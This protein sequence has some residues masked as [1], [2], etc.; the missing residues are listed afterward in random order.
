MDHCTTDAVAFH[1]VRP[2]ARA[3]WGRGEGKAARGAT[4]QAASDRAHFYTWAAK[5]GTLFMNTKYEP[6]K[7]YDV[8]GKWPEDLWW[9]HKLDHRTYAQYS[10]KCRKGHDAR[11]RD[12]NAVLRD[13]AEARVEEE[14]EKR[15]GQLLT[16][17]HPFR[18]LRAVLE[19]E[20]QYLTVRPRYKILIL[21]AD[22]RAG[23]TCFAEALFERPFVVT[24]EGSTFLDLKGFD[25]ATHDGLVLDNVNSFRQ[26]L[27]WRAVLQARNAKTKGGQSA[28][29]MYSR[30]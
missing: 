1:G 25:R 12:L 2:N 24:V 18:K 26:L 3:T 29:Q 9:Q 16:L 30:P 23:K 7:D 8:R 19:W 15:K 21:H 10:L 22:S 14:I 28:T 5:L 6:W 11:K 13:E 17:L 27:S 4:F 20:S